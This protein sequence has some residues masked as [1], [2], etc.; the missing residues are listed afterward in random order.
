ML[1]CF[2]VGLL[3]VAAPVSVFAQSTKSAGQTA[4]SNTGTSAGSVSP[5]SPAP[6]GNLNNPQAQANM[7]GQP[8]NARAVPSAGD[9]TAIPTPT[10]PGS[11]MSKIPQPP[12]PQ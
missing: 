3:L 1:K 12:K 4:G 10:L 2:F 9:A 7:A 8:S 11:K 6:S 5:A